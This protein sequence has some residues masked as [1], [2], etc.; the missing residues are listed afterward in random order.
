MIRQLADK[1][2]RLNNQ[3]VNDL[4]AAAVCR[5]GKEQ[6]RMLVEVYVVESAARKMPH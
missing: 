5:Q 2:A 6:T 1:A 4:L 3:A